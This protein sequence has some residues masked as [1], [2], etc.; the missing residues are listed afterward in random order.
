M[1][2]LKPDLQF[3]AKEGPGGE[4]T[5]EPTGKRL[6]DARDDGNV[7]KSQEINQAFTLLALFLLIRYLI[8]WLGQN[9]RNLFVTVY[10]DMP[11]TIQMYDGKMP[12][13]TIGVLVNQ[14][15]L[16]VLMIAAP[17]MI[18]GFVI[19]FVVNLVQVKWHVSTKPMQPKL[20]KLNPISG[21]KKIFSLDKLFELAKSIGKIAMIGLVVFFYMRGREESIFLLYDMPL[22]QGLAAMF[23]IIVNL[24]IRIALLY[25]IIAAADYIYQKHKWHEEMKMTK[26]EVKDEYKN[27]E[28]DPQIK[29]KQKA[30]MMEASRRRMMSALPQADVVIT[31]PTHYAVALRYEQEHFRAPIVIAKGTD[32]LAEKIKETARE[33]DIEIV[34]DKP[35]ARMLYANV[36]IGAEIPAELYEAVA[37]VLAFVYKI[38]GKI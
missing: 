34:E 33:H 7:A 15:L 18:A 5:E 20:S 17:F 1:V 10:E 14:A 8:G 21:M 13:K 29:S 36:P 16:E 37:N 32:H 35:L 27:Q 4:K 24:G 6:K 25:M 22:R 23:D 19:G 3:F 38:K 26:Q 12:V 31:N 11:Y 2:Y 30:R 9:F 28:G